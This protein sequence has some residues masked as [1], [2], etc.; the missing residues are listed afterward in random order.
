M[1]LEA[2]GP[3]FVAFTLLTA[4][5]ETLHEIGGYKFEVEVIVATL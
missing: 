3:F 5:S 1:T 4:A 2:L